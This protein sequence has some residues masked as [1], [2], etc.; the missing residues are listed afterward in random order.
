MPRRNPRGLL[1]GFCGRLTSPASGHGNSPEGA[2]V[3]EAQPL[4]VR[5]P[6]DRAYIAARPEH[7][8]RP[9]AVPIR[10]ACQYYRRV[11]RSRFHVRIRPLKPK[12]GNPQLEG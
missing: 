5:I 1:E 10:S 9:E 8:D 4:S 12:S 7:T 2:V 11:T 6:G 3:N